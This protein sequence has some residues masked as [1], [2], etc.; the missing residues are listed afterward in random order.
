MPPLNRSDEIY[1]RDIRLHLTAEDEG[2]FV[3]IDII[4][5]HTYNA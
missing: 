3:V 1:E 2:K 4:E 5:M